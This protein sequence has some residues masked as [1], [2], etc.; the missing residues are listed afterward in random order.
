MNINKLNFESIR[1]L[2]KVLKLKKDRLEYIYPSKLEEIINDVKSI[3]TVHLY[4]FF[5]KTRKERC[6]LDLQRWNYHQIYLFIYKNNI[7]WSFG[8]GDTSGARENHNYLLSIFL[9]NKLA[10][11]KI[12]TAIIVTFNGEII[13]YY[14]YKSFS[15]SNNDIGSNWDRNMIKS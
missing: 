9:K 11:K 15:Y 4:P 7:Y 2:T 6:L 3:I 1:D 8:H 13:S 12:I 14:F 10:R 5:N